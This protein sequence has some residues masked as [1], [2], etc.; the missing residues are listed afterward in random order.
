MTLVHGPQELTVTGS[1]FD[2]G[3]QIGI[4][5]KKEIAKAREMYL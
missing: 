4:F 1:Y 2:A 5:A 3:Y